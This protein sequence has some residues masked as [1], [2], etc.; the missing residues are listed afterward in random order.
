M[1][2]RDYTNR[3]YVNTMYSSDDMPSYCTNKTQA[4][5]RET[6]T[7][8]ISITQSNTESVFVCLQHLPL[9]TAKE[10]FDKM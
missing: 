2:Y 3:G 1:Q 8:F 9:L 6:K 7:K 10:G 4:Y 5:V